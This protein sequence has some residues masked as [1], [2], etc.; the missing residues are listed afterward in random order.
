MNAA[1]AHLHLQHPFV[2]RVLGRFLSQGYSAHDL[3]RV[4]VVRTR[5]DA[6]VRVIAFGRL[7]LFGRGATR[8]HDQ[9]VSVAARWIDGKESEIKP[10]AE[11]AD[12]K[13]IELLE[14]VLAESPSL[15][16]VSD[17]V[18]TRV[19]SAAPGLFSQ[20]WRH[21]RDEADALAHEAERKLQQRGADESSALR[22]IL[23]GQRAAIHDEIRRRSQLTLD[24][25]LATKAERDQFLGERRFM[26]ERL[27]AIERELTDEPPKIEAMYR[28]A[29]P[30]LEPVG[31]V[32]LWPE[33]RG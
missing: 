3:S 29:L 28:V 18:Q 31:L 32:V 21:I 22:G 12:R 6:L 24:D 30:R 5:H 23:E 27:V 20:L 11:E 17:V 14:Q 15:E 10:F 26:D 1:L 33:T 8:L 7:S 2:Q 25:F 4:T 13:A 16:V 9:L 19:R